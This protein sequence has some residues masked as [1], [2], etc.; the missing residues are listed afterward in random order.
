MTDAV[1]SEVASI[2]R[3]VLDAP[4]LELTPQTTASDVEL[5]DSFNQLNI[6]VAIE[7]TFGVKFK[8]AEIEEL[9]NVGELVALV[10]NKVAAKKRR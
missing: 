6:V 8:T 7:M 2:I 1:F 9:R 3:N 5:W 4:S 10:E